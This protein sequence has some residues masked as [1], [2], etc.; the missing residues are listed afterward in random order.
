MWILHQHRTAY[1]LWDTELCDLTHYPNGG[2]IRKAIVEAD[3]LLIPEAK[4]V[5]TNS[6]NVSERLRRFCGLSSQPLYHPPP[7]AEKMFC[8]SY[9]DFVYCPSRLDIMKRQALVLEALAKTKQDIKVYF[10]WIASDPGYELEIKKKAKTL[11]ISGKVK[12]L[13]SISDEDKR[14]YYATC[15]GVLFT[16]IDED[17]GYI[18]LEAMLSRKATITTTDAGGPLEFIRHKETGFVFEPN[19]GDLAKGL[20]SV[21]EHKSEMKTIGENA[22]EYYRSLNIEWESVIEKL[23]Q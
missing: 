3:R 22:Y 8:E 18:T 13:G 11:G 10:S 15:L 16:P 6:I 9:E 14:A 19:A 7:D 21:W 2:E 4:A 23:T 1:E 20:D 17:Y 5:Y 12:W